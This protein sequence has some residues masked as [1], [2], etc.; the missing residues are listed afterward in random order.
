MVLT[1][2]LLELPIS[3]ILLFAGNLPLLNDSAHHWLY[4]D[5]SAVSRSTYQALFNVIGVMYGVG[6]GND[7]FNLPDLRLRFLLGSNTSND[8]QLSA[9]G[10]SS[11]TLSVAE[12]PIHS[13]DQ[14]TLTTLA[15]GDHVHSISDP[16]HNHGGST[17]TGP[18][19]SG[20][21]PMIIT[22]GSGTDYGTHSHTIPMGAT[23]ISILSSGSHTHTV[24]GSTG[25]QGASQ[26]INT[27]PLYQTLHHIIR[28]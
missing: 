14:G 10:A 13:H 17:G 2:I 1:R 23:S 21:S 11:H 6:N 24:Q 22:G 20:S 8:S 26:M 7:T 18:Y 25:V 19:S 3:T 4:C 9:G 5:G 12:M 16:G 27:M 15:S 28:A